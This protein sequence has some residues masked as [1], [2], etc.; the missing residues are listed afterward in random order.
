MVSTEA[1][2]RKISHIGFI[3]Q[4]TWEIGLSKLELDESDHAVGHIKDGVPVRQS[5]PLALADAW[6]WLRDL[7]PEHSG[8]FTLWQPSHRRGAPGCGQR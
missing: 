4:M 3:N 1:V 6:H 2:Q 7:G 5:C 8:T